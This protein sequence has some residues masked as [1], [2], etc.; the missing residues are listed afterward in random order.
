MNPRVS[1][2]IPSYNHGRFLRDCLQR[3]L[4]QSF[5]EWELILVDDGSKDDSVAIAQSYDDPRIQV[6]VNEVNLGTYGTEHKALQLSRGEFIAVL[7]SDDL[8]GPDK[9]AR[10]VELL[11][12]HPETVLCYTLGWKISDTGVVD[13][14]DD[15]HLDWPTDDVQDVLPYLMYENRILASGV[16][17][18]RATLRFETSCRY[19]GD[20]V[21][22]LSQARHGP[23]ACLSDRMTFWRMHDNNTF[24]VSPK[25]LS[26]EVRV[27]RAIKQVG[28]AWA[29]SP[30][31]LASVRHGLGKND[32]NLLALYI[33]F[34]ERGM[35]FQAGLSAI[36]LAEDKKSAIKRTVAAAV[37]SDAVRR[38]F[39]T[40]EFRSKVDLGIPELKKLLAAQPPLDLR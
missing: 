19:S 23:V 4:G 40:E 22:L 20:W 3:V 17:F 9:L 35:A 25:Q 31:N 6:H 30:A 34:G 2:I 36:H 26:E 8:W 21:A 24:T 7:N 18:R 1:I 29:Y 27:R 33:F 14:S 10:Q 38:H 37:P 13:T 28:D 39:W 16:L 12:R 32:I 5:R 15:V 11:D